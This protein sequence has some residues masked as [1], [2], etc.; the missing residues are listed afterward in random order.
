M[1]S[2][3]IMFYIMLALMA[4]CSTIGEKT[5]AGGPVSE[6]DPVKSEILPPQ[7]PVEDIIREEIPVI[8]QK[9]E[10]EYVENHTLKNLNLFRCY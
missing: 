7:P 8:T 5:V 10:N 1:I 2:R 9:K 3:S 4:G 6:K